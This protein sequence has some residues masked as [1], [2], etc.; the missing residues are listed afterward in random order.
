MVGKER[1]ELSRREAHAPKACVSTIPPLTLDTVLGDKSS[2]T[3]SYPSCSSTID[4]PFVLLCQKRPFNRPAS[5]QPTIILA[6]FS[7]N[8]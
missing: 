1:L 8:T 6:T 5:S 2:S 4:G 7:I 3:V